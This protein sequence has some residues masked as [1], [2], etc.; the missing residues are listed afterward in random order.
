MST[1]ALNVPAVVLS[2]TESPPV[3]SAFPFASINWISIVAVELPSAS[4]LAVTVDSVEF[5]SL[6]DPATKLTSAL[7]VMALPLTVPDM[8]AVATDVELVR[9]AV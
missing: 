2:V 8:V 9:V 4:M 7:S 6:A 1:T 5:S 3:V